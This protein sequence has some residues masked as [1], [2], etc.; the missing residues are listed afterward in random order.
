[1]VFYICAVIL[2]PCLKLTGVKGQTIETLVWGPK[3]SVRYLPDHSSNFKP[4][5][6][7]KIEVFETHE[8]TQA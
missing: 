4:V 5:F 8:Y 6:G 7:P 3:D 1:M 2:N